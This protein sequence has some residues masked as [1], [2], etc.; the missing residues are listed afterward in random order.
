MKT[1]T[2]ILLTCLISSCTLRKA[3]LRE[4]EVELTGVI[5]LM[6]HPETKD[7]MSPGIVVNGRAIVFEGRYKMVDKGDYGKRIKV[8]GVA[9]RKHLPLF[10]FD[11]KKQ[12][13]DELVPQG[14]SMPPGTDIEKEK[15][16]YII[17][18]PKW[19]KIE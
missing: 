12:S 3:G 5:Q 15:V 11:E 14:I 1:L 18:D 9:V 19:E 10:I 16:C 2:M 6:H 13:G 7:Q 4:G 8:S 17:Q